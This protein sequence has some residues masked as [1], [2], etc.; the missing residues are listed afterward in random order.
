MQVN[1]SQL[2]PLSTTDIV[3]SVNGLAMPAQTTVADLAVVM[4]SWFQSLPNSFGASKLC[5]ARID[6]TPMVIS[7]L[8]QFN[9]PYDVPVEDFCVLF[10]FGVKTHPDTR[11]K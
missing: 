9:V 7:A 1:Y 6:C 2:S 5:V 10:P 11:P 8:D 4:P 3:T